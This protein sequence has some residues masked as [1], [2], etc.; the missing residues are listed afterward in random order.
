LNEVEN[1]EQSA[2]WERINIKIVGSQAMFINGLYKDT[3][4]SELDIPNMPT[5]EWN[6]NIVISFMYLPTYVLLAILF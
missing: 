6:C 2:K 1:E 5:T 3:R 4:N